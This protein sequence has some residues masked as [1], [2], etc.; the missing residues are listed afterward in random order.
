MS[1]FNITKK[2]NSFFNQN[3][4][5]LV[6]DSNDGDS[7]LDIKKFELIPI[8]NNSTYLRPPWIENISISNFMHVEYI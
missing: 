3:F 5:F 8:I 2:I 4:Q 1:F 6:G 7:D